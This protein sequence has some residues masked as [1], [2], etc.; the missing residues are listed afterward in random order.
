MS[1]EKDRVESTF[2]RIRETLAIYTNG[3]MKDI[4]LDYVTSAGMLGNYINSV[5][6]SILELYGHGDSDFIKLMSTVKDKDPVLYNCIALL[7]ENAII[8]A[9]TA[10]KTMKIV[11]E[12]IGN[13]YKDL[14]VPTSIPKEMLN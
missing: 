7:M 11:E 6:K 14:K 4:D 12:D 2:N 8:L 9:E 13:R 1:K 10:K 5:A 3:G